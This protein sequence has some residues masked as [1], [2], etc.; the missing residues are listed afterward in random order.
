MTTRKHDTSASHQIELDK[1]RSG[2]TPGARVRP[3]PLG[4]PLRKQDP[5]P[6]FIAASRDRTVLEIVEVDTP[7]SVIVGESGGSS[8]LMLDDGRMFSYA[9]D[10]SESDSQDHLELHAYVGY[11]VYVQV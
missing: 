9:R 3:R 11:P 8:L 5:T 4:G 7:A 2:E 10:L 1:S 6:Q